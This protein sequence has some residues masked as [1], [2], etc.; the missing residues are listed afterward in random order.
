MDFSRRQAWS[1]FTR[2][3][4]SNGEGTAIARALETSDIA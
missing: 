3:K 2:T 4:R 1:A